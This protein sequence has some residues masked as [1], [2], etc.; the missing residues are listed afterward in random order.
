MDVIRRYLKVRARCCLCVGG[1]VHSQGWPISRWD[2]DATQVQLPRY[3]KDLPLPRTF[4]GFLKLK[5]DE[6][7]YLAPL[8][9]TIFVL[10]VSIFAGG[11]SKDPRAG[12]VNRKI[13]LEKEKVA[14][15]VPVKEIEELVAKGKGKCAVCRCWKSK[16]VGASP[17]LSSPLCLCLYIP[18][19]SCS[20]L[21]AAAVPVLR[22]RAH[23]AQQGDGRQRRSVRAHRLE[24]PPRATAWPPVGRLDTAGLEARSSLARRGR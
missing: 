1:P 9:L 2:G 19:C 6:W 14:N 21:A 22:R 11:K 15:L 8:L 18:A 3:L 16:K 5:Q 13:E 17:L 20:C 12:R 10:L 7:L 4:A 24:R 23:E